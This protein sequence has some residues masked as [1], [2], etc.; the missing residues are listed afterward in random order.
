MK[1]KMT[2]TGILLAAF[3]L[4]GLQAS[5]KSYKR[6]V[7]EDAF[8]LVNEIS[9]LNDGVSWFYNWGNTPSSDE[10]ADWLSAETM[11]FLPMCW[12]A[13]YNADAIREFCRNHPETKALL[14]FNEPNF[15]NQAHMTP[16]EAAEAWPAVKA[17]ADELGLELVGPA[18]NY[19]PDGPQNDP[20]TWYERFVEL[21]GLDAFDYIAIHNYSGGKGGMEEMIDRFYDLYGKKIWVT[22]FCSWGSDNITVPM[23]ISSM[24]E[25]VEYL[26]KSEKVERYAW[27]KAKGSISTSPCYGLLVPQNGYDLRQLSE[28]GYV[29][30]Y[31]TDFDTTVWHSTDEIVPASEYVAS[32]GLMLGRTTDDRNP[33]KIEVTQFN[34]GASADYQFSIPTAG[35]YTL[36]LR[37]SGQGDPVRFDPKLTFCL[38]D[39]NGEE[40]VLAEPD[41]F[42]LSGDDA[43][44]ANVQFA[45][46]LPA[47]NICLRIKDGNRYQPSGIHISCMTFGDALSGV[48]SIA[49]DPAGS[50]TCFFADGK[51]VLAGTETVASAAVYDLNGRMVYAGKV[52]GNRIPADSLQAG[53]YLVEVTTESGDSAVLKAVKR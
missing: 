28:A 25:Q 41:A 42:T 13:N 39:E 4:T 30:T 33:S 19:S 34:S 3:A 35:D 1:A 6:G 24:I 8:F 31:M 16:E 17:L 49:V 7:G 53:I 29:Y 2:V 40:T 12:N 38:V 9:V 48:N 46:T 23:Q 20:Y 5:A 26:E 36:T 18:V 51:F 15:N 10:V 47:G 22:E 43:M 50:L 37:V 45:L 14:G 11:E 44:F 32:N 21:V 52:E 27:F